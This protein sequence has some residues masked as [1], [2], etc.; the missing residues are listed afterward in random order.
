MRAVAK[1][2]WVLPKEYGE[3]KISCRN[4]KADLTLTTGRCN[5][6]TGGE[7][8]TGY[9]F[10][11][12]GIE[13]FETSLFG[14]GKTNTIRTVSALAAKTGYSVQHFTRLFFAVTG[15][16]PKDYIRG[17]IL[18]EAARGMLDTSRPLREIAEAAGFE[19]YETFSR[20]IKGYF[21]VSPKKIRE[22]KY[23]PKAGT[24]PLRLPASPAAPGSGLV[25]RKP[26]L[27]D[28]PEHTIA[29]MSFFMEEGTRSFHKPWATFLKVSH[30]IRGRLEPECSYQ[31]SAWSDEE[32]LK[33]ITILCALE[34]T[35]EAE[36]EELF[37]VRRLPP[38]RCLRFVHQGD[39][40]AIH[41]TYRYIY[42][43]Y[44]AGEALRPAFNWEFQR[45][46]ANGDTEIFIPV[47]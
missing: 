47:G 12:E 33:G 1:L 9:D 24:E 37:S 10:I 22:M 41:E 31:W 36:Q 40:A 26:Q 32:A 8:L 17:R 11:K 27:I 7:A 20:S 43:E 34:T 46:G 44:L 3:R 45:Y 16:Q 2:A 38:S 29:G 4:G 19:D 18:T 39:I 42:A 21:G 13:I 14:S 25:N 30:R 35:A 15:V 28:E 23:L 5:M 6:L